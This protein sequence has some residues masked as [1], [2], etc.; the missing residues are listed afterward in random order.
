MRKKRNIVIVS[1]ILAVL[2][3]VIGAYAY[4]EYYGKYSAL[5]QVNGVIM[6]DAFGALDDEYRGTENGYGITPENP[7]IV[8]SKERMNNLVVL[9][10]SGRLLDAKGVYGGADKFYFAF[11]FTEQ[12]VPQVL[13]LTGITQSPIGSN[14]FPF[15]DDLTGLLYAY[16]VSESEYVYMSAG[17]SV[18]I[19]VVGADVT[20]DGQLV[21]LSSGT[22][23]AG[24]YVILF[25]LYSYCY[26]SAIN[27]HFR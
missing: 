14:Q 18:D 7:F 26:Q 24:E 1:I 9:N 11:D 20:I 2:L 4:Y 3:L 16:L 6:L 19:E 27:N 10:N 22:A 12:P 25:H 13:N 21:T 17:A 15:I 23:F 8:D 5:I